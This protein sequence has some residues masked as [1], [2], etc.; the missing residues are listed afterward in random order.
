M[1]RQ[2]VL[3]SGNRLKGQATLSGNKLSEGTCSTKQ[4]QRFVRS[5]SGLFR[6]LSSPRFSEGIGLFPSEESEH[7]AKYRSD[8]RDGR[9]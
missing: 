3:L 1:N 8:N 7:Y 4:D 9:S 6:S 2:L 5:S